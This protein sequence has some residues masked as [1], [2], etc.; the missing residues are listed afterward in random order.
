[1]TRVFSEPEPSG[2][3]PDGSKDYPKN[4]R[5]APLVYHARLSLSIYNNL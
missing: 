1:M 2:H 5:E 4:F 3:R